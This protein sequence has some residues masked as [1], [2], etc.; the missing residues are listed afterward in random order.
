[1]FSLFICVTQDG[2]I[3]IKEDLKVIPS[4]SCMHAYNVCIYS[5]IFKNKR[6]HIMIDECMLFFIYMQSCGN[7]ILG[8]LYLIVFIMIGAFIFANLVVAVVVTN[9]VRML[10]LI[11][12]QCFTCSIC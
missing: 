8:A 4:A 1:M 9:L 3:G 5:Y 12:F 2:W 11:I 7:D 10:H 6:K